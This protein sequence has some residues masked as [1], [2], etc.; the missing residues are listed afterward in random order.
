MNIKSGQKLK[1]RIIQIDDSF[2][3]QVY[4]QS[5]LI[6]QWRFLDKETPDS[7][8]FTY[9]KPPEKIW[10]EP[11]EKADKIILEFK[12][13]FKAPQMKIHNEREEQF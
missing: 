4:I 10:N 6:K 7:F 5:F 12:D 9:K 11:I 2:Y 8:V 13:T 3:P 1:V